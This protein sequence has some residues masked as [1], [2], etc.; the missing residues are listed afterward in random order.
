VQAVFGVSF[1]TSYASLYASLEEGAAPVPIALPRLIQQAVSYGEGILLVSK[2]CLLVLLL[3]RWASKRW[4]VVLVGWLAFEVVSAVMRLGFRRDAAMLVIAA[5]LLYHHLVKPLKTWQA[6][7]GGA[8]LLLGLL[9]F[10]LA[11]DLGGETFAWTAANEFQILFGNACDM[12]ARGAHLEI[13]PQLYFNELLMLIPS[14]WQALLPFPVLDPADWYIDL[15]GARGMGVGLMFGVVAQAIIGGDWV[16]LV[17]RG[18]AL[19]LC[20]AGIHRWCSRRAH[21]LWIVVFYVY[22][23]LWCYYTVRAT[24]FVMTYFV[25]YRF[26]PA[27]ILLRTARAAVRGLRR[28]PLQ[29]RLPTS[30]PSLP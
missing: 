5:V 3:R 23:C 2:I 19:G 18:T 7:A 22:L 15:W 28:G 21:S 12:L 1:N 4:R 17:A 25:V 8:G 29:R 11:R 14:R 13:P 6:V 10:G 30:V 27:M 26:F 24:T 16:E 20:F 9:A